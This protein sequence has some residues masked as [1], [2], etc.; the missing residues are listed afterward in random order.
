M[1]LHIHAVGDTDAIMTAKQAW[2]AFED[3]FAVP[4]AYEKP[5][6]FSSGVGMNVS[7]FAEA[8]LIE[9]V[10]HLNVSPL[11]LSAAR[12]EQQLTLLHELLHLSALIG[13]LRELNEAVDRLRDTYHYACPPAFALANWMFE[14]DA[15]FALR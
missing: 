6:L 10:A 4:F 1:K 14:V 2:D 13:P 7:Q 3:S 8:R 15:E 5:V 11:Y 12:D 9:G